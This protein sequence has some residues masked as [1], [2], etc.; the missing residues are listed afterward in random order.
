[1]I[2]EMINRSC[3]VIMRMNTSIWNEV[4]NSPVSVVPAK[5]IPLAPEMK[6]FHPCSV[7]HKAVEKRNKLVEWP[8]FL[9]ALV[10]AVV[11]L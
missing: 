6:E 11:A 10:C 4:I 2:L 9:V 5:S 1:M 7:E 8:G 3:M